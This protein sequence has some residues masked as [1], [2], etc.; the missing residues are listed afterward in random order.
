MNCRNNPSR[1]HGASSL[2]AGLEAPLDQGP[3]APAPIMSRASCGPVPSQG[4]PV[5]D[6][7]EGADE[8]AGRVC[9]GSIK[10]E[11]GEATCA[12]YEWPRKVG[13]LLGQRESQRR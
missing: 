11:D 1:W 9:Q 6:H 13:Y 10:V 4:L 3:R 7:V 8:I 12:G 5:E 2:P